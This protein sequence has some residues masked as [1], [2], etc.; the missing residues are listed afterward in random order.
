MA[1][2]V[3]N[4]AANAEAVRD[5][6]VIPESGRP[7]EKGLATHSSTIAWRIPWTEEPGRLWSSPKGH[8]ESDTTEET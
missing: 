3:E 6:C 2:V 7:L 4:P 8:T 5:T 1:L